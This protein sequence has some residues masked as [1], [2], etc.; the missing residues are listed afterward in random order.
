ML[1]TPC[2][3]DVF[4]IHQRFEQVANGIARQAQGATTRRIKLEQKID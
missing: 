4:H 1:E 3:S 2:H